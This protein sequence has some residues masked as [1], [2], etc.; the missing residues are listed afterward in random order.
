VRDGNGN[1]A[2]IDDDGRQQHDGEGREGVE[3]VMLRAMT[4]MALMALAMPTAARA[5]AALV[6]SAPG[7]RAVLTQPPKSLDLC[8]NEAVEV[9]FSSVT[10]QDAKGTA[11]ALG[12]LQAGS[13]LK[14]VHAPVPAIGSGAYT[15]HYR[16]LSQDGHVVEYGYQFS[17]KSDAKS[18]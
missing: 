4:I 13:D 10:L 14:C 1:E 2:A 18:P 6:K 8:F 17:V 16:V 5:H 11:V 3:Q 9:K 15:V 12:E 7:N